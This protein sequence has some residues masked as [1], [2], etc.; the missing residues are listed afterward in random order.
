MHQSRPSS[1][2]IRFF[3]IALNSHFAELAARGSNSASACLAPMSTIEATDWT[4]HGGG[5]MKLPHR[6]TSVWRRECPASANRTCITGEAD[7]RPTRSAAMTLY[8]TIRRPP[9]AAPAPPHL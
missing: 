6:H 3:L 7:R 4:A 5:S 9:S 1:G 8:P 2:L